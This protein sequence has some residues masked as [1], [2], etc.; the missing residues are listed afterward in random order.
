M[1]G[2]FISNVFLV[3]LL[4]KV[5]TYFFANGLKFETVI[6]IQNRATELPIFNY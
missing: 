2:L 1:F 3:F 5:I 6:A 4:P